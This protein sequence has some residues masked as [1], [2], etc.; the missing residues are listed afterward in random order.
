MVCSVAVEL[1]PS[2]CKALP[3]SH[4]RSPVT[5]AYY[6]NNAPLEWVNDFTYLGVKITSNLSW[7]LTY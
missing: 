3:I 7:R 4:K 6:I 2:K 5:H 1:E